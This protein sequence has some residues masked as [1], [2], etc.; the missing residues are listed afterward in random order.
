[1]SELQ[2]RAFVEEGGTFGWMG[3]RLIDGPP[4]CPRW[5]NVLKKTLSSTSRSGSTICVEKKT[6]HLKGPQK[7]QCVH[8][9]SGF[10]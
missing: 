1:M 9:E 3:Q 5:D 7:T 10:H 2:R 6:F 4:R 8:K